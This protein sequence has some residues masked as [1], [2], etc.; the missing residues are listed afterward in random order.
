VALA[1]T[2][3]NRP[4]AT[5]MVY[6]IVITLGLISFRHLPVDLLPPLEFPQLNV[7]VS[8]GNVGPEEMELI[9]TERI[10]NAVAGVPD[11]TSVT[12]SASEGSTTIQLRS[13]RMPTWMRPRTMC[14]P[15]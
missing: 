13:R 14:V 11:L 3:V 4:I 7:S 6:M 15:R 10:E 12:S 2:S 9:I 1:R 5:A 8:Y